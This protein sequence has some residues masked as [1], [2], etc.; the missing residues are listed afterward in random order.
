VKRAAFAACAAVFACAAPASDANLQLQARQPF[1]LDG[2]NA[3]A[4]FA[5][6]GSIA[7]VSVA[8]GRVVLV[9]RR[10]GETVVTVV[11][12]GSVR[13]LL[14]RVQAAPVV[15]APEQLA[16]RQGGGFAEVRYDSA[17]ERGALAVSS[18]GRAGD[19]TVS[20]QAEMLHLVQ[21][22]PGE[23]SNA[24]AA[25]S[26]EL[27]QGQRSIVLLDKFVQESP[28]TLDG[29]LLRGVHVQEADFEFH[30]GTA[31]WSPLKG[32]LASGGERA[33]SMS[34]AFMIGGLRVVPRA[35]WFPDSR[36]TA[37]AVAAVSVEFGRDADTLRVRADAGVGGAPGAALDVDFRTAQ[38]Q[39]WARWLWRP[40]AFAA[41]SAARPAGRHAE[42]A[43]TEKLGES[44]TL[45]ANASASGIRTAGSHD[46]RIVA[47]RA[48][49]REQLSPNLAATVSAG[50]GDYR[51]GEE[52][53]VRRTTLQSGLAWEGT[54]SGAA[55]QVRHQ[56]TSSTGGGNGARVST[57]AHLD[58]WRASA[59]LDAQ[60]QAPTLDLL[61]H[62]RNEVARVLA[63]LGIVAAQPEDILR[64]LR[65]NASLLHA[66]NVSVGPVRLSP[67]RVQGGAE[68]SW[69]GSG[70]GHP[71]LG[72]RV[73]REVVQGVVGG[74]GSTLVSLHGGWR[75]G[76]RTDIGVTVTRWSLQS[77][78]QAKA[79]GTGVQLTLRTYFDQ[80]L[81][82]G[83]G[84]AIRGQVSA[85]PSVETA[86]ASQSHEGVAGVEVVLDGTR[87]TR[88]DA[89]GRFEFERPGAGSHTIEAILPSGMNAYFT[90]PSTVTREAG[91]SV[92][93]GIARSGVQLTG[94]VRD[95]AGLPVAGVRVHAQS[96]VAAS[97]VTD[98]SGT[99]RISL[100]PGTA[101]LSIAPDTVPPG[102]DLRA[103]GTRKRTLALGAPATVNFV[104]RAQRAIEGRVIG[105][106][107]S[108]VVSID[109]TS[110][111]VT[112]DADG[113]FVLR[114]V[115]AGRVTL[116][117]VDGEQRV[118]RP[119]DVPEAA[120][121]VR[122]VELVLR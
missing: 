42:G 22:T 69:R 23:R 7:D 87:R 95:D 82:A 99:Y 89:D 16:A 91:A 24:L 98:S 54:Q 25:A 30:A 1:T 71:H 2:G 116:V 5:V 29:V 86:A 90:T 106:R 65:D 43:W 92:S 50:G 10:A 41:S 56:S 15:L 121:V 59:F 117:A 67:L 107:G 103:L 88:T 80:S 100:P 62:D 36:S 32:F 77:A 112:T 74:R 111:E 40:P 101:V 70:P 34:R 11:F 45:S 76:E 72:A 58:A 105:R 44:T 21:P 9:G 114:R 120:G 46:A 78:G 4:A 113:R 83:S 27:K 55:A 102:F 68:L 104:L 84:G 37:K 3:L 97:A 109:E 47:A 33:M 115:P 57:W 79:D 94:S 26:I 53:S 119:V 110:R 60:Q 19:Y 35:A 73:L 6:D 64:A 85:A 39:A 93:F 51:S 38:R 96:S 20:A 118:R 108:V 28:L 49:V 17:L 66:G 81:F 12:A 8:A 13:S 31:S 122:G 18:H 14:V 52:P 63:A 75:V 61:L 48:E